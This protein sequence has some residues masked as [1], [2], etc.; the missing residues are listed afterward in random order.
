MLPSI[1]E[2]LVTRELRAIKRELEEYPDDASVWRQIPGMPNTGGTLALHVAGNIQHFFGAILARDGFKR[3]R[4][5]EF[6]RRDVPRTELLAGIDAAIASI[7]RTLRTAS[8]DLL[9][10]PYPEPI[11]KRTVLSSVFVVHLMTHLAYHLGQLDYHRR[12]VTGDAK[13]VDAVSVREL[14][15]V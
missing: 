9:T 6:A 12:A 4:D 11:A 2:T 14:P 13:G 15:E 10:R 7:Q 8:A 3:D 5:A 1:V